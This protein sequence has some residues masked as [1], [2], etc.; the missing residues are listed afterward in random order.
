VIFCMDYL[1]GAM[2]PDLILRHH[3]RGWGIGLFAREGGDAFSLAKAISD[4]GRAPLIRMQLLWAGTGH[5]YGEKDIPALRRLARRYNKLTGHA[6]VQLS[7]FCEHNLRNA[8][9]F[10]DIVQDEA[11]SCAVVNTPWKGGF[12]SK[13]DNETHTPEQ[14]DLAHQ[15]SFDGIDALADPE[16]ARTLAQLKNLRALF[17]WTPLFN[18][19]LHV[20]E[21]TVIKDRKVRPTK[22]TINALRRIL[23]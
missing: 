4:K 2:Y 20:L 5:E 10:L 17:L 18:C 13:H 11:P 15:F 1:L 12:S 21:K 23:E 7:P 3:P 6:R 19:K 14:A 22:D 16:Y 9:R 8:D